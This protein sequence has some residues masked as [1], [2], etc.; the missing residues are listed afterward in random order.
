MLILHYNYFKIWAYRA[1]NPYFAISKAKTTL[2][3]VFTRKLCHSVRRSLSFWG[4]KRRRISC[5]RLESRSLPHK[6]LRFAQ[7]D[8]TAAYYIF[9]YWCPHIPACGYHIT[10]HRRRAGERHRPPDDTDH[11][12]IRRR[13]PL[14][15]SLRGRFIAHG[16][17]IVSCVGADVSV[18]P[19]RQLRLRY[20]WQ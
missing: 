16:N 1:K 13:R 12:P 18:R 17:L 10:S 11:F 2:K 5:I 14:S 8:I 6:I 7:N 4:A 3:M 20:V 19:C 9:P 15:M